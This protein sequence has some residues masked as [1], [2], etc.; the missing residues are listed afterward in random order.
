VSAAG[1]DDI[2][3]DPSPS[4]AGDRIAAQ[5]EML[6]NRLDKN[7]RHLSKWARRDGV[8]CLRLYDADIPEV[9]LVVDRYADHAHVAL[10]LGA[11]PPPPGWMQAMRDVIAATLG[12]P[13]G[14]VHIKDRAPQRTGDP[15]AQ[16]Q[17]LGEGGQRLTVREAGLSF[18]VNLDDYVDTGLFLD[19]RPMRAMVRAEAKDRRFL[20]LFAYTGAFTV[21]AAAGG[22]RTT[23][24]VDMSATYLGWA[25]ENLALNGFNSGPG[26][27]HALVREDAL[28]WLEAPPDPSPEALWDLVVVDPPTFSN[29]KRMR[30]T[31][32][33]QRDHAWLLERVMAR[34]SPGGVV[35]FSTNHRRFKPVPEAFA[36][37]ARV[38]ELTHRSIPPD[39]R[40]KKIHRAWR[41][42]RRGA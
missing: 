16:Y 15:S 22:A 29:S 35:Y 27:R 1:G 8:E 41:L 24:T 39:F 2:R 28:A 25:A 6:G 37:A 14:N 38:E 31:W 9:P 10:Y 7:L 11:K 33:V 23:T 4:P 12:V 36:A 26:T 13:T 18:L 32:D 5:A 3:P 21:Y 20:N 34:V 40:D 30:G 19:H 17:R 42:V